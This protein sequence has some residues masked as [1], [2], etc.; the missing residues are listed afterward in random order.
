MTLQWFPGHMLETQK[1]L[2]QA[3]SRVDAFLEILDARLPSASQ[4]PLVDRLCAGK[5]RL[6]LLN[7]SDLSDPDATRQWIEYFET[8]Q[9]VSALAITAT[10]KHLCESVRAWC[11]RSLER[12]PSR[13]LNLMVVGI[14]NT[15]KSTLM[16][17]LAGRKIARTGNVPAL[18]RHTQRSGLTS[19]ID[20]YDTPGILWPVIDPV[21]RACMLA[22]SGAIADTAVDFQEIGMFAATLLL[23]HYPD[24]LR[25]RFIFLRELPRD[26][27][28][29]IHK[30]GSAR[31][32]LKKGNTLDVQKACE[33]L[34]R[35][36]R[37]G[38]I[39]RI[40]YELP[41][42]EEMICDI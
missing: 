29:L 4:N 32:C 25:D 34:I 14:P 3:A 12:H 9:N 7:K 37:S 18:T 16:N 6:K 40:T 2:K 5:P 28:D 19:H 10:E 13:K 41:P 26:A 36:L 38:K 33:I 22:V 8:R 30:I 17:T 21:E 42:Q 24:R 20:L 27:A 11:T 31:G 35:E 39:G 23:T 15:G 1:K